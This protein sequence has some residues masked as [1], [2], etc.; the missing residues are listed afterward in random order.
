MWCIHG[1]CHG[2]V[3]PSSWVLHVTRS[4]RLFHAEPELA[5]HRH[6]AWMDPSADSIPLD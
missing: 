4:G 6:P 5:F 3:L 2:P 1:A